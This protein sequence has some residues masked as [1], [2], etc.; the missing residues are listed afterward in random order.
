MVT[1]GKESIP[2]QI[3]DKER[4]SFD[5]YIVTIEYQGEYLFSHSIY[6]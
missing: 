3:Y 1:N 6:Q 5:S 4:E 2:G